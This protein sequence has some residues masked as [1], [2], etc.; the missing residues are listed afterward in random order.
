MEA[1]SYARLAAAI[2][3]VIALLQLVRALSGW[4]I[5]INGTAL[6]LWPSW[7]ACG[8]GAVLAWLGFT[9]SRA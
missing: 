5:T 6:P 8:V 1:K 9:A 7:V 4:E 3:A 2:F